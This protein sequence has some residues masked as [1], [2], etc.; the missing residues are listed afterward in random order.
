MH[1]GTSLSVPA[2]GDINGDGWQDLLVLGG[3]GRVRFFPH[4]QNPTSPYPV[5]PTTADLLNYPVPNAMGITTADVN[6]DGVVDVL[7]SDDN[8]NVW[9]FHGN[10]P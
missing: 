6:E 9:E 10:S 5:V 7:I 8:G 3:D 2:F 1:V 4:T